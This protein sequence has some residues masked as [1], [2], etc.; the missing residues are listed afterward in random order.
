MAYQ[1]FLFNTDSSFTVQDD[2]SVLDAAIRAGVS[3]A[4]DCRMGGCGTCRVKLLEGAVSYEDEPFGLAPE[5]AAEGYALACQAR[6]QSDLVIQ[7]G[8]SAA[9]PEP[10][11]R[12]AVVREV[13]SLCDSVHHLLLEVEGG[14]PPAY[15]AGQYMN[16]HLED[17]SARS[18]SMASAPTGNLIDFHVRRIPGG[19]FTDRR[20]ALLRAG[21]R[22]DITLPLGGFHYR[23]ADYRP[24][25]MV[26]T[27]TGLA[28][29]RSILQ[30][31]M[32]DPDCPPVTLYWG[33]RNQA[34]LYLDQEIRNWA[35]RLYDFRYVPVL[36]R[37]G[38]G[39]SGRTG[40]VQQAVL[41]DHGSLEEHAI[42]L[43]GAPAMIQDAKQLFLAN[44]ASA[45]HLYA[46]SF[47][48]AHELLGEQAAA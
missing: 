31:L 21:D 35:D 10:E 2:E 33:M 32:D 11:R 45:D 8:A 5:E 48:F 3:L 18:F 15:L 12:S 41:Q 25:I 36:S 20:L 27:G 9:L 44:G 17:G 42:Y 47:S 43:C 14:A 4:H 1:V 37:P 39:W 19:S 46:D 13:R 7:P 24:L 26:A 38:A 16:V 40:Y 34:D 6:P 30:S 23:S 28:P 29:I 22:I